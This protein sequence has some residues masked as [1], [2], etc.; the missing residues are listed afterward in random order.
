MIGSGF[1]DRDARSRWMFGYFVKGSLEYARSRVGIA[2]RCNKINVAWFTG[3][4][5][6]IG[7]IEGIRGWKGSLIIPIEEIWVTFGDSFRAE[8]CFQLDIVGRSRSFF[9]IIL[10]EGYGEKIL[11]IFLV[12]YRGKSRRFNM[13]INITQIVFSFLFNFGIKLN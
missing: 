1:D 7:I 10:V 6:D 12:L 11:A 2:S 3:I 13:K 5:Q 9:Y 8:K 4:I